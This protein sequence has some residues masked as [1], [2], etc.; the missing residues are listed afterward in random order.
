MISILH[1]VFILG[2]DRISSVQA[3]SLNTRE[4]V[5]CENCHYQPTFFKMIA[6]RYVRKGCSLPPHPIPGF[7]SP[8]PCATNTRWSCWSCLSLIIHWKNIKKYIFQRF[9][10]K[11]ANKQSITCLSID[12]FLGNSSINF[13]HMDVSLNGGFSP[14]LSI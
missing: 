13:H 2:N 9:F 12:S 6:V 1:P 10:I 11:I 8:L 3:E 5:S 7:F 4:T 14:K